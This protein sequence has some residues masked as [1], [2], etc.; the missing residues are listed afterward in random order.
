M[1]IISAMQKEMEAINVSISN[2]KGMLA[3]LEEEK[4][5]LT[6]KMIALSVD[7]VKAEPKVEVKPEPKYTVVK[8]QPTYKELS[9]EEEMVLGC[10]ILG[11]FNL[12]YIG[13]ADSIVLSLKQ[14]KNKDSEVPY[15]SHYHINIEVIDINGN[16][17][18]SKYIRR[19]ILEQKYPILRQL[20][21]FTWDKNYNPKKISFL[22]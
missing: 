22:V 8:Q 10:Q 14:F 15:L 2:V 9:L 6:S 3:K 20:K 21:L 17:L 19:E 18:A 13:T 16:T 7:M 1:E 12:K 5:L 4:N 11:E